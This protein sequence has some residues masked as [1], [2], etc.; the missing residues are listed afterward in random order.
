M[1]RTP[2]TLCLIHDDERVLLGMKKRGFGAGR[3]NGFGGKV[4]EGETIE[5][6]TRR[7]VL[8][9]INVEVDELEKMGII[10]FEFEAKPG[11]I[12][13]VHI[14]RA[15]TWNGE[16]KEGEEM[17]PRW[18]AISE[19][20]FKEMW[21]DDCYWMPLFFQGKKFR[22]RFLFGPQDSVLEYCLNVVSL[23]NI[24]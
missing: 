16:P 20:P 23:L 17:R 9:E 3:W 24:C 2:L 10:D 1:S 13:E 22:G 7:E 15:T 4:R 14:Y 12:L 8:E 11:D 21:P 19:I 6:A 5:E 18:Y